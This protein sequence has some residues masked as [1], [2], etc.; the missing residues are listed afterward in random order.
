MRSSED[1]WVVKQELGR[2]GWSMEGVGW[3]V[4]SE[5]E[6]IRMALE[7]AD[8][9]L[10]QAGAAPPHLFLA[11]CVSPGHTRQFCQSFPALFARKVF[12]SSSFRL[13]WVA[14]GRAV[15]EQGGRESTVEGE[16]LPPSYHL[17]VAFPVLGCCCNSHH[18]APRIHVTHL[19]QTFLACRFFSPLK[20]IFLD[21]WSLLLTPG[22]ICLRCC[23]SILP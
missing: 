12:F 17:T 4:N 1:G 16:L 23:A 7:T 11:V 3:E 6:E 9:S 19:L 13:P 15:R 10:P 20:G 5:S 21:F 18:S 8:P 14:A 2:Q 22:H